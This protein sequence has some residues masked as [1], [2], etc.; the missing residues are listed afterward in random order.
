VQFD[1]RPVPRFTVL[2]L[3]PPR[4]TVENTPYPRAGEPNPVARF[5]I[6]PVDGGQVRWADL[7]NYSESSSLV[8][9]GGWM[10]ESRR[11]YFYVQD[12]AQTWLD[13]CT[14]PL[15]GGTP[16]RLFRETT[17]A[18]VND[19]GA[20]RFLKDS[21]FLLFSERTGWKHLYHFDPSGKDARA[22]TSGPWEARTLHQVDQDKGWVY[23]SG[24]RDS[25][26]AENLYRVKL[27]G[28]QL[29]R[30][31]MAAGTHQVNVSP[32]C[33][34]FIDTF[35]SHTSPTRVQLHQT[36]GALAR[37]LDTNPVYRIEEYRL[38]KPEYVQIRT[39]DGFELEATVMTPPGFDPL[40]RYPVWFTTYG[41]PHAPT[42]HDSWQGGL[43][44][45]QLW[46]QMGFVVFKC[47]PRSASGKGAVSTWSAYR[48]LGE[49]E[50]KDIECAITWLTQKPYIDPG[51][52]GMSGH[53][54]GGFMT[55]FALT[56]SKL[57]AAGIAGAPVTD[58]HNYDTIYTERY[59]NTPQENPDGYEATSVVK[60]ARNLHGKLLIAH[61][62]MDD[63]VHIQNSVQLIQELEQADRDFEVMVYPRSRHGILSKHYQ[64]LFV[65][66]MQRTLKPSP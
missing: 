6:V 28:T 55:A 49:Q 20:P 14:V 50:L 19:P 51:R 39:P 22:I 59:M 41:G 7:S 31:T 60:A 23:F 66:F 62:I 8:V 26:L 63:N 37:V 15:Q 16:T 46:A 65:D 11:A 30:L 12:R 45:D 10:P 38:S 18:W 34:L 54:Y 9:R 44:R 32:T 42:I 2:D 13:F 24:S 64:R 4:Q 40:R 3:I 58:W 48:R 43:L 56:H 61:G 57:F 5:G 35:S 25:S 33:N 53:S 27:D 29:E 52:I 47:D 1:D 21:S 17:K 36:D